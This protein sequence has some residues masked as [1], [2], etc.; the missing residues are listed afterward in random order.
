MVARA[1]RPWDPF[2]T[3]AAVVILAV[4]ASRPAYGS[5]R[6]AVVNIPEISEKYRRTAD[7]EAHFEGLRKKF[8]QER[9][10]TRDRLDRMT[11]SLQEEL[12]PDTEEFRER[13]KQ[14]SLLDA[15]LK[16]FIESEGRKIE[17]GLKTS[18][19]SIYQDIQDTIAVVAEQNGIDIVL[20]CDR[21][22]EQ[23]PDNPSQLRQQIMLQKVL[24]WRPE[25]DLTQEIVK[26]LNARY[27]EKSSAGSGTPPREEGSDPKGRPAPRD[28]VPSTEKKP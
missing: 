13:A 8:E 19:R 28:G 18:M 25:V 17:D 2:T 7:L 1:F 11:K 24:Y 26:R 5:T 4:S 3:L 12:K 22:P 20:A 15:E 6:V 16:W 14:V 9:D 23:P 27:M 21:L 10:A